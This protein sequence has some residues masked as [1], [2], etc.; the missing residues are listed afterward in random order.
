LYLIWGILPFCLLMMT[1]WALLKPLLRVPG[2][3]NAFGNFK[4]FLFTAVVMAISVFAHQR[5][6]TTD[7]VE[8]V[9]FGLAPYE[10]ASFFIYPFF[11]LIAANI[12]DFFR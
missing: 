6:E 8:F 1:I 12:S 7:L 9:T 3:E 4:V 10:V 2:K 11:L 5:Q